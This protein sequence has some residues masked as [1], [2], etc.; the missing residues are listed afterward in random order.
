MLAGA[1]LPCA[2]AVVGGAVCDGAGLA[3]RVGWTVL[4]EQFRRCSA[5]KIGQAHF[6]LGAAVAAHQDAIRALDL[7]A[8]LDEHERSE[9]VAR[10]VLQRSRTCGALDRVLRGV[11]AVLRLSAR[12]GRHARHSLTAAVAVVA[13]QGVP[14]VVGR[15]A[16]GEDQ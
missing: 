12:D 10:S 3:P 16:F 9:A 1:P 11:A 14:G 6:L 8:A 7:A 5:E 15:Q 2:H 13:G 4:S